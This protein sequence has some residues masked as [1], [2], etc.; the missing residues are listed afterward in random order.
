MRFANRHKVAEMKPATVTADVGS[1][2]PVAFVPMNTL[3]SANIVAAARGIGFI[4]ARR[5]FS[6]VSPAL[7]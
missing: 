1:P 5:R 7:I 3:A 2:I 6:A 4:V